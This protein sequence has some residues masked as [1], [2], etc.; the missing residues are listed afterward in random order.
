ML[1]ACS[2]KAR[3]HWIGELKVFNTVRPYDCVGGWA[4]QHCRQGT[5]ILTSGML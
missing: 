2:F 1:L 5:D 4:E 3:E